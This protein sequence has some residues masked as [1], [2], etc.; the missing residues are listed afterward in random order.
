MPGTNITYNGIT[1]KDVLTRNITQEVV[2]DSTGLN[3]LYV[4][5]V[6]EADVTIIAGSGTTSIGFKGSGTI[7]TVLAAVQQKILEPRR[8]FSM[9]IGSIPLFDIIPAANE[10][11]TASPGNSLN[12]LDVN[13]G[14]KASLEVREMISNKVARATFR[15]E[16]AVPNCPGATLGDGVLSL[17][18]WTNDD[19]DENWYTTRTFN[20]RLRVASKNV[21]LQDFRNFI[22]P[23][24][25]GGFK[26][27][28]VSLQED[29]NGL[30]L[31]FTVVDEEFYVSCPRP[32]TTWR[33]THNV[34]TPFAGGVIGDSEVRV[35]LEGPRDTSKSELIQLAIKII[36]N[37]LQLETSTLASRE[38]EGRA[39]LLYY[40]V[41]EDLGRNRITATARVRHTTASTTSGGNIF[42]KTV[43]QPLTI[44]DYQF[45]RSRG[46][47]PTATLS[48]IVAQKLTTSCN[49]DIDTASSS[50]GKQKRR[51]RSGAKEGDPP[52]VDIGIRELEDYETSYSDDHG[53]KLY[54]AYR[55]SSQVMAPQG[56][57][58]LPVGSASGSSVDSQVFVQLHEPPANMIVRV[59]SERVG[60]PPE[61]PFPRKSYT[62][63]KTGIV[64]TLLYWDVSSA[65][66]ALTGD[67]RSQIFHVEAFFEYGLNREP[68]LSK[69]KLEIGHNPAIKRSQVVTSLPTNM[70]TD[71]QYQTG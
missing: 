67:G 25:A 57:V 20:G 30:E 11:F 38:S 53:Q 37:K 34:S 17:R 5:I 58:G 14:P 21:K 3:P 59:V 44:P 42:I 22:F 51:T 52:E 23:P 63:S 27:K 15:I 33:G 71:N 2:P 61:V 1:F 56:V 70:F 36:D 49:P 13:N 43:G 48:N 50:K 32:A 54:T 24:I 41:S 66:V 4:R 10:A 64:H 55:L 29:P 7:P 47:N 8:N 26:R 19:I 46:F 18:F 62:D 35:E 69:D 45:N 28:S 40:A 12:R 9:T 16:M 65:A 60:E 39:M 6:V 31:E 68:D